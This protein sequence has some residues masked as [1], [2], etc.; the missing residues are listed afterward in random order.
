MGLTIDFT[1]SGN[2]R[3]F[4]RGGWSKPESGFTWTMDRQASLDV[5]IPERN[6]GLRC[7]I[8][9]QPAINPPGFPKQLLIVS[10]GDF[11]ILHKTFEENN[12]TEFSFDIP[13]TALPDDNIMRLDFGFPF[14]H[15]PR[16]L[17]RSNDSRVLGAAVHHLS[18]ED[19]DVLD[20]A[21]VGEVLAL[22]TNVPLSPL[23][24]VAAVCMTHNEPEFLPLWIAHYARQ[25]GRENCFVLDDGSSDGSTAGLGPYNVIRLPRHPY[26]PTRQTTFNAGFCSTLLQY[27]DYVLYSDVD[28]FVVPDPKVASTI[29]EYCRR[30]L[31]PV[32]TMIG[33]NI[34]HLPDEEPAW[35]P[36]LPILS[37]RRFVHFTA[38][39]CKATLV[40][41]P[42]VWS[43][44]SH[45][46]NARTVFDHLY[47]FHAKWC[48]LPASLRRL[49]MTRAMAWASPDAGSQSR[50]EDERLVRHFQ[51]IAA[52][53]R[54]EDIDFDPAVDPLATYVRRV[55]ESRVKH[56]R[57]L[58][59][60]SLDIWG[61]TIW[62]VPERFRQCV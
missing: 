57:D 4:V 42:V 54:L 47:L 19:S 23:P 37:Q 49:E 31:P 22:P 34:V 5:P 18:L 38:S 9:M 43:P 2:S 59:K 16:S 41:R 21:D 33:L 26:D 27:Y 45:S 55:L 30:P 39:M 3:H 6:S 50:M 62:E 48:D 17:G 1:P 10:V 46:A 28:E 35:N 12:W 32:T 20:L 51:G 13:G 56:H 36:H 24:R 60:I 25:V 14:A 58:Y 15:S 52:R 44:G 53:P 40:R 29:P 7:T 61:Q 11:V 8:L